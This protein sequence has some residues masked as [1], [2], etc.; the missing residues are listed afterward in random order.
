MNIIEKWIGIL[1][2]KKGRPFP[3]RG[4]DITSFCLTLLL[5]AMCAAEIC[6]LTHT[7]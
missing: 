6:N 7:A 4:H 1:T 5:Y 2:L 3:G